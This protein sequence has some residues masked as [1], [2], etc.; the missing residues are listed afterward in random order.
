MHWLASQ[1]ELA[2]SELAKDADAS[3]KQPTHKRETIFGGSALE[4]DLYPERALPHT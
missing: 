1:V 2:C 4:V 3:N